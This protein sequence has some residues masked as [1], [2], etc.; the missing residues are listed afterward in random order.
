MGNFVDG[1]RTTT[2]KPEVVWDLLV[3]VDRWPNTFTPHLKQARLDGAVEVGA[4]GWV[5]SK[6]P[7]PRSTFSITSVEDGRSWAW[8]GK[9]L[10]LTMDFDHRC[11]PVETGCRI[12][13]DVDL[14][15]PLAGLVRPIARLSYRPQMNRA[16]D[17]LVTTAERRS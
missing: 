1:T 11:E 16:L 6:L 5:Q 8:R 13:F 17:L 4:T 12:T 3:D 9:V 14:S 15:G 7:L 10:W 2:A